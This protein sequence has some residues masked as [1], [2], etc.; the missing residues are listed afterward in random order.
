ME[1]Y[2]TI[3]M[4][5]T[6]RLPHSLVRAAGDAS[7][8]DPALGQNQSQNPDW[9]DKFV[10]KWTGS[11]VQFSVSGDRCPEALMSRPGSGRGASRWGSPFPLQGHLSYLVPF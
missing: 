1:Q 11:E 9:C 5:L 6:P 4:F 7:E 8:L 2:L 3:K 10:A